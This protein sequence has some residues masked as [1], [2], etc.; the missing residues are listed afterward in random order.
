M[1]IQKKKKDTKEHYWKFENMS[2]EKKIL[3]A[4]R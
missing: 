4:S 3:E 1:I 2:D